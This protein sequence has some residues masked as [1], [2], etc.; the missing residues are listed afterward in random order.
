MP[1]IDGT[2]DPVEYRHEKL[3]DD[4][5]L[6]WSNDSEHLYVAMQ[7]L[8]TGWISVGFDPENRMQGANYVVGAVIDG[9]A[10][11]T[12]A[13]DGMV[14]STPTGSTAYAL[15]TGG[16]ILLPGTRALEVAQDRLRE[17]RFVEELG[18]RPA[19]YAAVDHDSELKGAI[20]RTGTP[21]IVKT[22]REGYDGK[23]QWRIASAH[24]ADG[25]RVPNEGLVYE[26]F[27]H[28]DAE[29]SVILVRGRDGELDCIGNHRA[30]RHDADRIV[31]A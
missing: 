1:R 2:I 31:I 12:S 23:G 5:V 13:C 6:R 10:V 16:P 8:T 29:F 24:E 4:F 27:V 20:E 9:E 21:G 25:L 28:F 7:G 26:G 18:G 30:V 14:V 17:K 15:S 19:P 22:R 3:V 11:M